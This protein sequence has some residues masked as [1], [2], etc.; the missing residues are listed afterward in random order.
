ML[1]GLVQFSILGPLEVVDGGRVIELGSP[2]QRAL[3]ALLVIRRNEVVP[4]DAI[5]AALWDDPPRTAAQIVRVYVSHLRKLLDDD[6]DRR[7]LVTHANGY[8]LRAPAGSV[9]AERFES[10]CRE[11][12]E[13]R[14]AGGPETAQ[15]RLEE[16]LALWRGDPLPEFAYDDFAAAETRRLIEVHLGALEDR[17][18]AALATGRA[19]DLVADIERLAHAHPL[20][21]RLQAQ[22]MLALY[23]SDRQADALAAYQD[24][25]TRLVDDLGLEPGET[26]RTLHTRMLQRDPE[27][28]RARSWPLPAKGTAPAPRS[29]LRTAAFTAVILMGAVVAGVVLVARNLGRTGPP[30]ALHRTAYRVT[31]VSPNT[32]PKAVSQSAVESGPLQGLGAAARD[33]GVHTVTLWNGQYERAARTSDLVLLAATPDPRAY[34][35]IAQV[36]R[37]HPKTR[38][39]I[40]EAITKSSVFARLRNV[41]GVA[42]DNYELGYLAGFLAA[43]MVR[44]HQ[45]I[46]AVGGI[47]VPSVL[48]LIAGYRAGARRAR[49]SVHVVVDYTKTFVEQDLCEFW[50]DQQ[51]DRRSK[52]VFDVAGDC[53]F[54]A[55][56]AAQLRGVWGIGVDSDLSYL[57]PQILA[58][59]VKRFD[60]ETEAVIAL[61]TEGKLPAAG[62]ITLNLANDSVGLVGISERVPKPVR[63]KLEAV[64]ASLRSRDQNQP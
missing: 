12:A 25:R 43:L 6:D 52:V 29:R 21:E 50:A 35:A 57:G 33:L 9:D 37:R 56:Q 36:A 18:D 38:F 45:T 48:N 2:R 11:A 3:F 13:L 28:A 32:P 5:I 53:G 62:N 46:S 34:E 40:L 60:R 47:R 59:A 54:G 8:Q 17:F 44:P 30:G 19:D 27:L 20:R 39:V 14:A 64:A 55:M 49:P 24:V 16:A 23:R 15:A 10:L 41:S 42:Y 61:G 7:V 51:I 1:E 22:L 63:E 58:S 31:L 26:L 4:V